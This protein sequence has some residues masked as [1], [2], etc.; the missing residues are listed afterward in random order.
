MSAKHLGDELVLLDE[1]ARIGDE[2]TESFSE[3]SP[4]KMSTAFSGDHSLVLTAL[5]EKAAQTTWDVLPQGAAVRMQGDP[6]RWT[7]WDANSCT[8]T[9]DDGTNG[10]G[11]QLSTRSVIVEAAFGGSCSRS[12]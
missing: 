6:P 8:A 4:L 12:C 5:E 10:G 3:R 11:T 1:A 7:A 9:C 2:S